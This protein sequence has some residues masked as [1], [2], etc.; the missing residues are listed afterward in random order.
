MI[1]YTNFIVLQ[2]PA[3]SLPDTLQKFCSLSFADLLK[4]VYHSTVKYYSIVRNWQIF[5]HGSDFH[6][7]SEQ[8]T[9]KMPN[10][11]ANCE[12]SHI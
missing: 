7:W 3:L 11:I 1:T 9:A 8:G 5:G 2:I 6:T 12:P 10:F 4:Y